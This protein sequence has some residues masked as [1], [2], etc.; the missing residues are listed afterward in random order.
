MNITT[1][2]GLAEATQQL[3]HGPAPAPGEVARLLADADGLRNRGATALLLAAVALAT[4]RGALNALAW[5]DQ[6][7]ADEQLL[8]AWGEQPELRQAAYAVALRWGWRL[9]GT[10]RDVLLGELEVLDADDPEHVADLQVALGLLARATPADALLAAGVCSEAAAAALTQLD[11]GLREATLSAYAQRVGDAL[12]RR[13]NLPDPRDTHALLCLDVMGSAA[14]PQFIDLLSGATQLPA[15][16]AAARVA[17]ACAEAGIE[18]ALGAGDVDGNAGEGF[19]RLDA[20]ILRGLLDAHQFAYQDLTGDSWQV[21]FTH[22]GEFG[23]R[24]HSDLWIGLSAQRLTLRLVEPMPTP[25]DPSW[26]ADLISRNHYSGLARYSIDTQGRLCLSAVASRDGFSPDVFDQLMA[27]L[28]T[29]LE[30][31]ICVSE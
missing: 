7:E 13:G 18:A 30:K 19:E 17:R 8:A 5:L 4:D 22:K 28:R 16:A 27:D 14:G 3:L 15:A 2:T 11:A 26:W 29:T 23:Q 10:A 20:E 21:R 31:L 1:P 25:D 6:P 9:K 24:V 12:T